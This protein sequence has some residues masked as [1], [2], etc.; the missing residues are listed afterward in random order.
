ME[1]HPIS[2]RKFVQLS[3][4]A[5]ASLS[6]FP[7]VWASAST[8]SPLSLSA[9]VSA[10]TEQNLIG[11]YGPWATSLVGDN[12][13]SWSFRQKK[14]TNIDK[15]RK[16]AR[17]KVA[18]KLASPYTGGVPEVTV[19]KT[20]TYD[21]LQ[22][23]EISWQLPYGNPTEAIVLK[24]AGATGKLPAI[25]AFHDHG[26]NK[27]FGKRKITRTTDSQHP[28]M[29]THQQEYYSGK[30]W[31]NEIAKRGYVVL[32]ADAFTFASRRVLLADV[33]EY[34]RNGLSDDNPEDS[35]NIEAYNRWAGEH[36]HIM[37]KSLFCAGTTWPGVFLAED[38]RAL[39]VLCAREDVDTDR[40]GCGGLSGGGLRTALAG[41]MDPRIKCAVCV[42]FMSTWRDFLLNKSFTHTWMT[43]IPLLAPQLDFPEVF[44]L[45]A[46]LATMV[47]NDE[48]DFLYTLPE[49]K[50]ADA[51]IAEVFQKAG[52]ADRYK[53]SYYPGPHKFDTEMQTEAFDW[54]DRWLKN[55]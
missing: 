42:G 30:A 22:V 45:R 18:E 53:C 52:A 46:P 12:I 7:P 27:Y 29:V 16:S 8:E 23:E 31:A 37:A 44:A 43:Y 54:F 17:A 51:M 36:E 35:R 26:G 20:Y 13:P 19:H 4:A 3:S 1:R 55:G 41:G 2:R 39:D 50:R 14:F 15:W 6:F 34:N 28:D 49:M 5:A 11:A 9:M 38:Q 40:I 48:D 25:L 47:L 32:V 24:P 10:K 21:G 33:P